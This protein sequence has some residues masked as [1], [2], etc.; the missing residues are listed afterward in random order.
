MLSPLSSGPWGWFLVSHHPW[1]LTSWLGLFSFSYYA[2]VSNF[3]D[4]LQFKNSTIKNTLILPFLIFSLQTSWCTLLKY[5]TTKYTAY[6][7]IHVY[8]YNYWPDKNF[9]TFIFAK[10][11]LLSLPRQCLVTNSPPELSIVLLLPPFSFVCSWIWY[12]WNTWYYLCVCEIFYLYKTISLIL[13]CVI[14]K[15][16]RDKNK[17]N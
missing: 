2:T 16:W 5:T 4:E 7:F 10:A 15:Q 14:M 17:Q 1:N 11:F 3:I 9:K 8:P 12:N 6:A 13:W